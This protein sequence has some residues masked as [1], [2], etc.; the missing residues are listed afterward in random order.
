MELS[1]AEKHYKNQ[2][3]ACKKY[4]EKNKQRIAEQRHTKRIE[5]NPEIKSR[6]RFNQKKNYSLI[7]SKDE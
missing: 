4:Y 1:P 3:E 2:M 5:K 7:E 6:G